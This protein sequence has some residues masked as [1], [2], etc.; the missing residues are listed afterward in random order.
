MQSSALTEGRRY[1]FR[2]KR[3][4][5]SEILKVKLVANVGRRVMVKILYEH[6]PLDSR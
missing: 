5:G 1:A 3:S 4:A 6:G 2:E